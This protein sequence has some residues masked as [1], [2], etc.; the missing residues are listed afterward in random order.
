MKNKIKILSI[1]MLLLFSNMFFIINCSSSSEVEENYEVILREIEQEI[2][3]ND[4]EWTAG[5]TSVFGP[6][7]TLDICNCGVIHDEIDESEF[8]DIEYSG[9][10]PSIIDWRDM[11][12]IN[13]V[14]SVK[15]Q[16]SCGSCVAFGAVGALEA[17]VQIE[18][19][20]VFD[21]DLSESHLFFC[22]GGSCNGGWYLD[23]AA[24]FIKRTGVADELCFPYKAYDM[25]C[26]EK[27]SNWKSRVVKVNTKGAV[28]NKINIQKAL[29]T[30]GPVFT[31]FD[32]YEDFSSYTGGVYEHLWGD[33][34]GG[35]CVTVVG[36]DDENDYWICKNSWGTGWGENGYFNIKYGE[37]DICKYDYYLDNIAGNIPPTIPS[38]PDPYDDEN[39]VDSDVLLSW[40][41]CNDFDDDSVYYTVYLSEGFYVGED[42]IIAEKISET[43]LQYKLKKSSL[44]TWQVIAE[45]EHGSQNTV[46]SWRFYTRSPIAPDVN[47]INQGKK[48]V[49]YTFTASTTDHDGEEYYWYFNWGDDENSGWIGPYAP[50]VEVSQS[51]SWSKKGVYEV[52]IR[53]KE[54]D[55][56]SDWSILEVQLPKEKNLIN[57]YLEFLKENTKWPFPIIKYFFEL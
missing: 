48:N 13:W 20:E 1:S 11:D 54:D 55:V 31:S 56:M 35:H 57:F 50:G 52:K 23:D 12:G 39:N 42:D 7:K 41:P 8:V 26:D 40:S 32:V 2:E 27:A 49:E 28:N 34:R 51:H 33:Y 9:T 47:G 37:V 45:D 15:N 25:D 3:K 16:A 29:V 6:D 38:E 5:Y 24:D 14:T 10:L 30:Y 19:G 53:Y 18:T 4:A 17:V 44:Y 22:G 46:G 36:Y 21:C 43:N